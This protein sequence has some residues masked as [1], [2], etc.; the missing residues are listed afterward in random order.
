MLRAAVMSEYT[1]NVTV[2]DVVVRRRDREAHTYLLN[3][4][5]RKL[6]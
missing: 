6:L 4:Y 3:M 2:A 1:Y 5:S